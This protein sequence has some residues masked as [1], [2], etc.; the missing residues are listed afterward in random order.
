MKTL[1]AGGRAALPFPTITV[2][3]GG[4]IQ[5]GSSVYY[6][7]VKAKNRVGYNNPSAVRSVT[8]G[9]NATVTIAASSFALLPY[10]SWREIVVYCSKTNDFATS[11]AIAKYEAFQSNQTTFN[12]PT[13]IVITADNVLNLPNS[14]T[15]ASLLP[16]SPPNG[17]RVYLTSVTAT[18][19]Y[20]AG[21]TETANGTSILTATG[22][23]L[24]IVDD[25]VDTTVTYDLE[26]SQV[27]NLLNAPL[28]NINDTVVPIRYYILNDTAASVQGVLNLNSYISNPIDIKF[29]FAFIGYLSFTNFILDTTSISYQN[30]T[31]YQDNIALSKALPVNSALVLDVYPFVESP[32]TPVGTYVTVYPKIS[33]YGVSTA[34]GYYEAPL[35]DLTA[36]S[37]ILTQNIIDGQTR[38]VKSKRTFYIY[39]SSS[40]AT[41]NGNDIIAPS[42]NPASGRWLANSSAVASDSIGL[43]QLKQEVITALEDDTIVT[44]ITLGNTLPYVINLDTEFDYFIINGPADTGVTVDL[45]VSATL[46]NNSTLSCA[47]ELRQG[48]APIAFN[49]SIT[50]PGGIAPALSGNGKTD[51]IV[52]SIVKDDQGNIRKR[53]LLSRNDIG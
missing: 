27:T 50:F 45:D 19:E 47:V 51:M 12:T 40:T 42:T 36:L 14:I 11:R 18:Y 33:S 24:Y 10:E 17:F 41:V 35:A 34:P 20:K 48:T 52:L 6:F 7:W 1:Y 46:V 22:G 3:G 29:N 39:D 49:S 31:T 2:S 8:I 15:D 21:S 25:I 9:N 44:T 16:A 26:L 5:G 13:N 37:A 23:R 43:S 53:G 28:E 30:I 32:T 38:Y 4:A